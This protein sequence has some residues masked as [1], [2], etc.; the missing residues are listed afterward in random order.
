MKAANIVLSILIL[1]MALA[2]AAF[3]YFLFEKRDALVNGWGKMAAAIHN[4]SKTLDTRSATNVA[5]KLTPAELSHEKYAELDA[6]LQALPN[7]SRKIIVERDELAD[8][9]RRI[10]S[11][12]GVKKLGSE[13]D[14]RA[15]GTYAANK[16]A[17]V[18]GVSES[19]GRRDAVY[20]MLADLARQDLKVSLNT[21]TLA[22]QGAAGLE[23]LAKALKQ[24]KMRRETYENGLRTIASQAGVRKSDF[25][26]G[27]YADSTRGI[28]DGVKKIR[29][30]LEKTSSTLD[31]TRRELISAKNEIKERDAAIAGLN[32]KIS[33]LN[34]TINGL[35]KTLGIA[36]PET[37][38]LWRPGSK[39]VRA[40][41]VG[42]VVKV[43]SDYGYIAINLGKN[44]L[45]KQP[46]TA[47]KSFE[48]NPEI[49]SGMTMVIARGSLEDSAA[50]ITRIT[51]DEV[52]D[53][54][55]TANI[56]AGANAIKVGDLV[57]FDKAE[58]K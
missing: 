57:Y 31:D 41:V 55:S 17:V 18:R 12:V 32:G 38:M 56:P 13:A 53:E 39:E 19:L 36:E 10:G 48:V 20:K 58:L 26:D 21:N 6:K 4:T 3:S 43:N 5:N 40:K 1:I 14:F 25:S 24:V 49:K 7:Q 37:P 23:P 29:T 9:L 22:A 30:D 35:K 44:S 34:Y 16:D 52:G 46:V 11:Q 54:C 27:A 45:V 15:V 2:S 33:D 42:E 50:F 47:D 28:H 8:A 51:L